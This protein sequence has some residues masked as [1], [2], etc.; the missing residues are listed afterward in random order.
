M[1]LKLRRRA[2]SP[3]WYIRGTVAG[4]RIFESA[5]TA[6]RGD[7][8][9][10]RQKR[11]RE[12]FDA[13]RL[14]IAPRRS[15]D[16]ALVDYARQPDHVPAYI[17]RIGIGARTGRRMDLGLYLSGK[18]LDEVDDRCLRAY[19]A[20][21][22]PHLSASAF[23]SGILTPVAAV[24]A[25][26][27]AVGWCAAR[28]WRWNQVPARTVY[29]TEAEAAAL[30]LPLPARLR[31]PALFMLYTGARPGEMAA[32]RAARV[33]GIGSAHA[34]A[35]QH[36]GFAGG[37]STVALAQDATNQTTPSVTFAETKTK[38]T[39]GVPLHPLA[40]DVVR[41]ALADPAR[42]PAA[43]HVFLNA[44][45]GPWSAQTYN[46][47]FGR[48]MANAGRPE[49]T[50]HWLRHTWATWW[51]R[52]N[53]DPVRLRKLGGWTTLRMVEHYAHAWPAGDAEGINRLPALAPIETTDGAKPV[54]STKRTA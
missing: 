50:P 29:L 52:D 13:G 30:L 23:N 51:M 8:E 25:H 42:P 38:H 20:D 6:D 3:H 14:G 46:K 5:G 32:L 28:H 36:T 26:A 47:A 34:G 19:W 33:H 45:G 54:Q 24:M 35:Q 48:R 44:D 7:A 43:R 1:P 10:Y 9:L 18:M 21:H 49:V 15:W 39:R 17:A 40:A 16:E 4:R 31:R 22:A 27:A 41:D 37:A 12:E 2:G 53:G 11:E